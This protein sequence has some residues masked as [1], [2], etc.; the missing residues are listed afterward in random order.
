MNNI[1]PLQKQLYF[2]LD[3]IESQTIMNIVNEISNQCPLRHTSAHYLS[4]LKITSRN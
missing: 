3:D 4:N 2:I 1:L